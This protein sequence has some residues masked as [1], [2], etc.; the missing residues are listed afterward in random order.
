MYIEN[1]KEAARKKS[2]GELGE[3][4]AIAALVDKRFD[5]IKNLNDNHMNEKFADIE[6]EKDGQRYVIGVKARNKSEFLKCFTNPG[7]SS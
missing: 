4:S 7:R 2:P 3:V 5:R 1:R 6:C